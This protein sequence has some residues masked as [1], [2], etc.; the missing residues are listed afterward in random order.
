MNYH[1]VVV[2]VVVLLSLMA[3]FHYHVTR[4]VQ[5]DL[6]LV[7]FYVVMMI[8]DE[9]SVDASAPNSS[10][11]KLSIGFNAGN[12]GSAQ[13]NVGAETILGSGGASGSKI[14]GSISFSF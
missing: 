3:A 7:A 9:H 1:D 6:I 12:V 13:F 5:S 2:D 4:Y 11:T 14:G 10:A 8:D